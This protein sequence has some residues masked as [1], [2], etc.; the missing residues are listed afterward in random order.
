MNASVASRAEGD[1]ET[2]IM[3]SG[4]AVVN[5]QIVGAS[6][7]AAAI[8]IPQKNGITASGEVAP[9]VR[10]AP[11]TARTKTTAEQLHFAASA[12][13]SKIDYSPQG[14]G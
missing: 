1:H 13:Q 6:T 7:A 9:G 3:V 4:A 2:R 11:I 14:A 12:K 5:R 8:A 10:F